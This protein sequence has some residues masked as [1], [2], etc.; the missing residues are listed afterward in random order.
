MKLLKAILFLFVL[1]TVNSSKAN[2]LQDTSKLLKVLYVLK[3]PSFIS[4]NTDTAIFRFHCSPSIKKNEDPLI[5]VNGKRTPNF[6]KNYF[7]SINKIKSITVLSPKNDS[8][9]LFGRKGRYGVINIKIKPSFNWQTSNELYKR[10]NDNESEGWK[11]TI[12][13]VNGVYYS[14][15]QKVRFSD[16]V[17]ED[18]KLEKE[19]KI[20]FENKSYTNRLIIKTKSY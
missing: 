17:I 3:E 19:I 16:D 12:T 7:F 18:I 6:F 2:Q 10:Q 13:I 15:K 14:P 5:L 4:K 1:N 8:I 11:N 20:Y 9:K